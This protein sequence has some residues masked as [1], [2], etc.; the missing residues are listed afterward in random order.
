MFFRLGMTSDVA[1]SPTGRGVGKG[2]ASGVASQQGGVPALRLQPS[3]GL[4]VG[5]WS[6]HEPPREQ[7]QACPGHHYLSNGETQHQDS[8]S[9]RIS[10]K[11]PVSRYRAIY[12]SYPVTR[13]IK[14]IAVL[15]SL[16]STYPRSQTWSGK[17]YIEAKVEPPTY[18]G[19]VPCQW[20]LLE[21]P[22][23]AYTTRDICRTENSKKKW[24]W[25]IKITC[26]SHN[27]PS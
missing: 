27:L 6:Q 5:W 4:S 10:I 20:Q 16:L 15:V 24:L 22:E 1:H 19:W 11:W 3:C 14:Q 21:L 18:F 17:R 13:S 23:P 9:S 8:L 2:E 12:R 26:C 25:K 7:H